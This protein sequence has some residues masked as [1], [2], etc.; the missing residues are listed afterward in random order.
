[1]QQLPRTDHQRSSC[2]PRSGTM[3]VF[4]IL[5]FACAMSVSA[6]AQKDAPIPI[7]V[8]NNATDKVGNMFADQLVL[9]LSVR[10]GNAL[11]DGRYCS[12]TSVD[13]LS[14]AHDTPT[15]WYFPPALPNT[16]GRYM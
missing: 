5:F 9:E 4:T 11:C 3:K 12:S 14:T 13:S 2:L 15:Y 1:M 10:S 7:T 16:T 8:F 6:I